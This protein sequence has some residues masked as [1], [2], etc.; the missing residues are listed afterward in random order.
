MLVK[1][2]S[3]PKTSSG[4]IQRHAC[5]EQYLAGPGA[6]AE[7]H[8]PTA[9]PAET[10]RVPASAEFAGT[11]DRS[12]GLRSRPG[13]SRIAALVGIDPGQVDR[14]EPLV[15]YGINSVQ[16]VSLAGDLEQWL[17]RPL[18]GNLDL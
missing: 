13:S 3:I 10:V 4:K 8:A 11:A 14:R 16:A 15:H 12:H 18:A 17:G 5:R 7:W 6:V 2:L 1:P 9:E